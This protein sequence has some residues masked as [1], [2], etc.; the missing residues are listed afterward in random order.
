M[1]QAMK[2]HWWLVL[3]RGIAALLF[4]LL[5]LFNPGLTAI[6]LV[7]VFGIYAIVNGGINLGLALFGG[8]HAHH[9]FM[10][11]LQGV[12][13]ALLGVLVLTWPGISMISLLVVIICFAFVSGIVEIV[14]AFQGRD[15]WLGLSGLISIVFGLYALRFPG[16]GALAVLAVIGIYAIIVGV[17]L[18]IA[19]F[20][21]RKFGSVPPLTSAAT[22]ITGSVR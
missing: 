15:L 4:G 20:Q 19:S 6:S 12:L 11:G 8:S 2:K 18:I 9:R 5:T 7:L 1:F 17:I 10:L 14:V 22:A 3:L 21:V 13:T 16:D